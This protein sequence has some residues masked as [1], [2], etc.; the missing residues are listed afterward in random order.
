MSAQRTGCLGIL[1]RGFFLMGLAFY[2]LTA[3][4]APWNFRLGGHFHWLPGWQ[5]VGRMT[6]KAAGGEYVLWIQ[7]LP[8]LPAYQRSP[9]QGFAYLCTPRGERFDLRLVGDLPRDH[10]SDLAGVPLNLGMSTYRYWYSKNDPRPVIGLYGHFTGPRLELED[11]GSLSRA[12]N[13]DATLAPRSSRDARQS[14]NIHVTL[15]ERPPWTITHA[16]PPHE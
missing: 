11:H 9:L 1:L 6:S 14:E 12:F 2:A 13:P 8:T 4:L 3:L 7:L 10:G 15:E 16:C 5:G